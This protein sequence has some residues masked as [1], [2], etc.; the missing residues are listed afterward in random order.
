MDDIETLYNEGKLLVRAMDQ[1]LSRT[2]EQGNY[3]ECDSWIN[4]FSSLMEK[5][6]SSL[7]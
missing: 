4:E 3:Y 5:G 6:L 2:S 1:P 7:S